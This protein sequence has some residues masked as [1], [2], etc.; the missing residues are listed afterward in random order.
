MGVVF[1][2]GGAQE[3]DMTAQTGDRR[4]RRQPGRR[5]ARRTSEPL[6]FV[7]HQKVDAR[8]T[9]WSVSCGRSIS[10]SSAITARRCTSKG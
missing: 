1:E 7:D 8:R 9:A 10:I 4:D 3:Q 2:R 6:G 5:D